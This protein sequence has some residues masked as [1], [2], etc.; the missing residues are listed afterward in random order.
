MESSCCL[1]TRIYG[2][3]SGIPHKS[4]IVRPATPFGLR[5]EGHQRCE[6]A[7]QCQDAC[8]IN[9]CRRCPVSPARSSRLFLPPLSIQLS[10]HSGLGCQVRLGLCR[11]EVGSDA[12]LT[13]ERRR[14]MALDCRDPVDGLVVGHDRVDWRSS[15]R[16]PPGK[17]SA[18]S[19]TFYLV[20]L[21]RAE[22]E[23]GIDGDH[24]LER[25][26]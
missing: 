10:I 11:E 26:E 17:P 20:H 18:K 7:P 9:Q 12:D 3:R 5:I 16:W 23:R 15:R 19:E 22:E 1:G 13:R 25:D 2:V 24:R 21:E 6:D 4:T 14:L 8:L